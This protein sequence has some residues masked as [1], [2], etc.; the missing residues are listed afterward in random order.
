MKINHLRFKNLNSLV[1]EWTIDF[2]APEYVS[3]GIFAISGPTGAGKSTILDAICLALYGRTPRLKNI[4]KSTNE[5][6]SRQTGECFAEVVFETHEGQFRA[7]WSQRR[8]REKPDGALQNPQHE[9]SN[10]LTHEVLSSQLTTTS[11]EI[12]LKTGMDY[13]RFVQSMLLAQGGFAAFLEAS[14]NERAPI[15]EQ[16]TGTE[17]YSRI[18]KLVFEKQ[19]EEK[20]A[21]EKLEVAFNEINL[22]K[23]EEEEFIQKEIVE[24]EQEK[25][26]LEL[27]VA[28][29]DTAIKWLTNMEK[30]TAEL[31]S[32]GREEVALK[33]EVSAFRPERER[34]ESALKALPLEGDY[35]TL[36]LTRK[37]QEG[38][39]GNLAKLKEQLPELQQA[40]NDALIKMQSA[41]QEYIQN[42]NNREALLKLTTQVRL[43][44]QELKQKDVSISNLQAALKLLQQQKLK[45]EQAIATLKKEENEALEKG[46]KVEA[47]IN[48]NQPDADLVREL[49]GIRVSVTQLKE[50]QQKYGELATLLDKSLLELNNSKAASEKVAEELKSAEEKVVSE[51]LMIAGIQKEKETL[52]DGK[53]T[54]AIIQQ[55]DELLREIALLKK[56][57]TYEEERSRLN[58]GTPCPLC[59]SEHHPYALGN[60]PVPDEAEEEYARLI[61]LLKADKALTDKLNQHTKSHEAC[62]KEAIS[63]RHNFDVATQK[64]QHLTDG[65]ARQQTELE[66][67][68]TSLQRVHQQLASQLLPF[69]LKEVPGKAGELDVLLAGLE[70][71]NSI[72]EQAQK[73]QNETAELVRKIKSAVELDENGLQSCVKDLS[74]RGKEL[75]G[76]TK[77]GQQ[78]YDQRAKLF[79]DRNVDAEEKQ[80]LENL[81][82]AEGAHNLSVDIH[83]DKQQRHNLSVQKIADLEEETRT[84]KEELQLLASSFSKKLSDDGFEDE[85]QFLKVRLTAEDR[86]RLEEKNKQLQSKSTQLETRKKDRAETLE[87]E[88]QKQLTTE[89]RSSLEEQ[90][91]IARTSYDGQVAAIGGLKERL[92]ENNIRKQRG[93]ALRV[94]VNHQKQIFNRW[95]QLSSLIGSADGKK[96]RN[97]AQGLT[98]EIMVSHANAQLMKLSDRYLLARD[99][100]EPLELNVID[101]YQ[102][103]EIRSTKN[104]SGGES[105]I[106]SLALALGLSR[107]ASRKVR[108]DSLFLDEGF[109]S[110]DEDTLETALTTLAGLRQDGKMIGV[111]SHVG[112]MKERINTQIIVQPVREGRSVLSGP[113]CGEVKS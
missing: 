106:V 91:K 98:L 42:N 10:A 2:T 56:I 1:G 80:S 97:F 38:D 33:E 41:G 12:E 21:L 112:A 93:E 109:G 113:G 18:S 48:E 89:D 83:K 57:G 14:G 81:K 90:F 3:D 72:W 15:L 47:Y 11:N 85:V 43:L 84:R 5:I 111:I 37:Q 69:G 45:K 71:R 102:A 70:K 29:F 100:N 17:I 46:K 53:E 103:G 27:K 63:L 20:I 68:N 6:I 96:Y 25:H 88:K 50:K 51:A 107:M 87:A 22:L 30:L 28:S 52:L 67:S 101:N 24:K 36:A 9:L 13:W 26:G 39:L 32:I 86:N 44:D 76:V 40:M 104:L 54:E 23:P 35:S 8:A 94:Q 108:V 78:I 59:G 95:A 55:K 62:Q 99:K 49:S 61:Q 60:I 74:E 34:L 105:F 66:Q 75:D 73:A 65:I 77:E 92:N 79:G 4:S 7:F 19:K 31:E 64:I 58:D 82:N 16:M 110:L